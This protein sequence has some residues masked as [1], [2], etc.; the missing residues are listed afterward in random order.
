VSIAGRHGRGRGQA[1]KEDLQQRATD[2]G[3][4]GYGVATPLEA[5]AMTRDVSGACL[6]VDD[7]A[8]AGLIARRSRQDRPSF[9]LDMNARARGTR[10][11]ASW[12]PQPGRHALE[13]HWS[14]SARR[15]VRSSATASACGG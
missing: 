2:D 6:C 7:P 5:V 12:R 13:M 3:H 11:E 1:M 14:R 10:L 9:P 8:L 15:C 4:E